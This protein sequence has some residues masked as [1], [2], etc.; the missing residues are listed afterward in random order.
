M[1]AKARTEGL[2]T[3]SSQPMF[4]QRNGHWYGSPETAQPFQSTK[5]EL[6]QVVLQTVLA[7]GWSSRKS[8]DK[9][10]TVH[11]EVTATVSDPGAGCSL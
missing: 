10:W 5:M 9:V 2:G 11:C 6:P 8:K 1:T 7:I 3:N 4:P